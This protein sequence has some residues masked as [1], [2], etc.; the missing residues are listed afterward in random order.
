MN[1]FAGKSTTERNK[2]IAAI[3]LG[4]VSLLALYLAFGPSLFASSAT[5]VRVTTTSTPR[6]GSSTSTRRVEAPSQDDRN[7]INSATTIDY[8]P[9]DY[10]APDPGRNIFAFTE[11][12][13]PCPE[14]PPPPTPVKTIPTPT[15]TPPPPYHVEFVTPQNIYAGSAS[16][17]LE[18]SG[19]KFEPVSRIY[20]RMAEMPTQ[21]VSP[22][23]LVA[24]VPASMISS[25]GS[26]QVMVQ[27]SDG[28]KYSEQV[29]INIQAPPKPQ[30][31]YV[32][33]KLA[34]RGNNDTGYFME[35]GKQTPTVARLGDVVGGRF[36]LVSISRSEAI[37]QD[38]NLPFKHPLKLFIP[39]PGTS[40]SP[41]GPV[42]TF[43]PARGFT[44]DPNN[45]NVYMPYPVTPGNVTPIEI[46]PGIPNN[47]RV[48][49]QP[50]NVRQP[51]PQ[52]RDTKDDDDGDGDGGRL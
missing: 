27:S 3:I 52:K 46:A 38:V 29:I 44:Q 14:C 23:K 49:Q 26:A 21:F 30:F 32:G 1:L 7:L 51:P 34:A 45:P 17:R 42:T 20:F 50:P 31:Q 16:F 2:M 41:N 4:F 25:E 43:G 40:T 11:P 15:P 47:P 24:N 5:S 36:R 8:R 9:G 28:T 18:V 48:Q 37:F 22:Q 12:P 6:S 10:S 35:T 19:D 13:P 33:T 39:P